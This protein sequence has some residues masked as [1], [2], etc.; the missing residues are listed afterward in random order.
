ME[1]LNGEQVLEVIHGDNRAPV[2]ALLWNGD[3][4]PR[5][6][7]SELDWPAAWRVVCIDVSKHA[8]EAKRLGIEDTPAVAVLS[9]G[10]LLAVDYG[11]DR[12]ACDRVVR[13]AKQQLREIALG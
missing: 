10:C 9:E 2:V 6:Q 13:W 8:G 11:C 7:F 5:D 12:G 1:C 3:D 4:T